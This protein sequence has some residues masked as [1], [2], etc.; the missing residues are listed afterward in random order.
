[1]SRIPE[2]QPQ[3][4]FVLTWTQLQI[5]HNAEMNQLHPKRLTQGSIEHLY[6]LKGGQARLLIWFLSSHSTHSRWGS[7][8]ALMVA[9]Q[10][11]WHWPAAIAILE[12]HENREWRSGLV[13]TG[14]LH[15]CNALPTVCTLKPAIICRATCRLVREYDSIPLAIHTALSNARR[16]NWCSSVSRAFT[17][18]CRALRPASFSLEMTILFCPGKLVAALSSLALA[19]GFLWASATN[20]ASWAGLDMLHNP[21]PSHL[22]TSPA[23]RYFCSHALAM[24]PG[25]PY[26]PP[27]ALALNQPS[28]TRAMTCSRTDLSWWAIVMRMEKEGFKPHTSVIL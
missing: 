27:A 6:F 21:V 12:Q 13:G 25:T 3:F 1:M 26:C 17:E 20:A 14:L 16:Y 19:K 28:S 11:V 10:W 9:S 23:V 18:A 2:P 8:Q 22:P 24:N 15:C 4:S 7:Y 5:A